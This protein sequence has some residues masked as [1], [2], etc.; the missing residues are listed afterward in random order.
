MNRQTIRARIA[1]QDLE[2][3][4]WG[5]VSTSG[6]KY[7]PVEPLPENLRKDGLEVDVTL[8]PAHVLGTAMWGKHIKILDI[9]PCS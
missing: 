2:G 9:S 5:L 1:Y 3:G 7:V 8:E 4:F 6:E